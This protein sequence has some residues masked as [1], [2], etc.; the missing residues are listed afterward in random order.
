MARFHE[1]QVATAQVNEIVAALDIRPIDSNQ[2][3]L[4]NGLTTEAE[5]RLTKLG[6]TVTHDEDEIIGKHQMITAPDTGW[7]QSRRN[8][9]C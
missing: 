8:T 6:Y 2:G 9:K 7:P 1:Q 5:E 3:T 4:Y